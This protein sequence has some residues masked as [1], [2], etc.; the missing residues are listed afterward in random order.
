MYRKVELSCVS[1]T[2][3][4]E[5]KK[6]KKTIPVSTFDDFYYSIYLNFF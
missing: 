1:D 4:T 5:I 2:P 6:C 3:F